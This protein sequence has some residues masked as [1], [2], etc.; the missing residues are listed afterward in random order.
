MSGAARKAEFP[1]PGD[2]RTARSRA[3]LCATLITLLE[4]KP[5]EQVTI[6]EITA[7]AKIGYAT[8]FRHYPDKEALL[9]DLASDEIRQLSAMTLPMLHSAGTR[10]ASRALCD[11]VWAHRK[12]WTALLTGGAAGTV[13]QEFVRQM[14]QIAVAQGPF[15]SWLPGDLR[16]A[17]SVGASLEI[18]A[19]WLEQGEEISIER[20]ADILDR[21]VV[22]PSLADAP[23]FQPEA[24]REILRRS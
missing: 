1:V 20:M 19:W 7:R 14:R 3:A 13:K 21:L 22:T 17:F 16:V 4:E 15:E 10:I 12:I 24:A 2:A 6:R 11:Y 18:L 23:E 9:N 5:F 8:F